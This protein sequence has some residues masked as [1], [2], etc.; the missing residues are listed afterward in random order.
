MRRPSVSSKKRTPD[1]DSDETAHS[2]SPI[3]NN[4]SKKKKVHD[5]DITEEEEATYEQNVAAL[6]TECEQG[7]PNKR[8]V[9]GLMEATFSKRRQWIMNQHPKVEDI[10]AN[11][12]PLSLSF[13]NVSFHGHGLSFFLRLYFITEQ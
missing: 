11:F 12:P 10:F 9:K 2:S 3:S 7:V 13:K 8:T 6:I 5:I 4:P 1:D